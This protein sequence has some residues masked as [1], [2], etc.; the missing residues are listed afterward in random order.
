MS[1]LST[2]QSETKTA[3]LDGIF[4]PDLQRRFIHIISWSATLS[5]CIGYLYS[6][7]H[8]ELDPIRRWAFVFGLVGFMLSS[9]VVRLTQSAQIGAGF[10][11]VAGMAITL[12]PAYYEGGVASPY[13]VWFLIVPLLGGL[14]LG[15]RIA[16]LAGASGILAMLGLGIFAA[17]LPVPEE[18]ANNTAMLAMN[19]ILAIAFCT[20]LGAIVSRLMTRSSM[21]LTASR[22]AE[23]AKNLALEEKNEQFQGSLN[24][25]ANAIVMIGASNTIE[26]FNPAAEALY[27]LSA[28]DAIGRSMPDILIPERLRETHQAGFERYLETGVGSILGV[29]LETFS[30]RSDGSEFPVELTI[31]EIA[32]GTGVR[33]I[34]YIRDLTERNRL[35]EELAQTEKQ[36]G[37][38]RRLE[39]IGRLSG[40]VAHDFNNLLMAINGNTELLLLRDDLPEA[41]RE[42]LKEIAHA[43]DRANSITKQLLTFSRRDR[44]ETQH[45]NLSRMASSLADML[46]KVLPGSIEITLELEEDPWTVR[47]EEA[48][49]EQ[50]IMNLI[51]NASDAMPGGG[52]IGLRV[53]NIEI[54]AE[55][56]AATKDLKVGDHG[57]VEVSDGGTGMDAETLEHIFDPF[58][59]TK[60]MG[61]GTGL[62]LSTTYG[63]VHQ[64]GGAIGVESE[65]GVG[66]TFRVFLPRAADFE[67]YYTE[68]DPQE[69]EQKGQGATILV[70]EDETSVRSLVVRTLAKQGHRVIEASDGVRGYDLAIRHLAAIDLVVTDV[71]MPRL[72]GAEMIRR[73]RLSA[74]GLKVIYISGHSANELDATDIAGPRSDFLYKPFNLDSLAAAVGRLLEYEDEGEMG[75]S[76]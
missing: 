26:V 65:P 9:A 45:I 14:L 76:Q 13:S 72:G 30:I 51:L 67:E 22:N 43:G 36:I 15:P 21:D 49:L 4:R 73:L 6:A 23:V 2:P 50:A 19:Q 33:F 63:I 38:Q 75:G 1:E 16:Y 48:R 3:A 27:G 41:A 5:L 46:E 57:C 52:T 11:V 60:P 61:S 66:S 56:A 29:K 28:S 54:G 39:A 53:F 59:T 42:G 74:P 40:G 10:L 12:V 69:T 70:V 68:P 34:A 62:G 18:D 25:A 32:G 58:F 71:V 7:A 37:L 24:L 64:S 8:V 44:L 31:Q 35:R 17:E 55:D 47:S 20:G